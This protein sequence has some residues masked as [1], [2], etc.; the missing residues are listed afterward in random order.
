MA[1][2]SARHYCWCSGSNLRHYTRKGRGSNKQENEEVRYA[3]HL[4]SVKE[5]E[6]PVSQTGVFSVGRHLPVRCLLGRE[7]LVANALIIH[8]EVQ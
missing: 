5:P 6:T 7:L 8:R 2:G 4:C 1:G 3:A